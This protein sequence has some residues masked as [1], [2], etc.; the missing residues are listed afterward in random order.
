MR[1]T[2]ILSFAFALLFAGAVSAQ[3]F[4][5]CLN[6]FADGTPPVIHQTEAMQ[7]RALCFDGFAVLHSGRSKTPIFVAER[8]DSIALVGAK[9]R[10][11]TDKFF[12]DARLPRSE[13]AELDDYRGSGFDRGHLAPVG[14]MASEAAVAQSFSL[15]NMIPQHSINNR[16]I[17]VNIEK[18]TRKYVLRAAGDIYVITGPVFDG[19]TETIG[20]NHVWVPQ[21]LFKLIY[22]PGTG[23]RWAYW[24]DNTDDAKIG[25]PITYEE[26]VRR[27]GIEFMPAKS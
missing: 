22:D 21:H 23:R 4:E 8:L 9:D 2:R 27:T 20:D 13:R 3:D 25:Q 18:A 26:L 1:L 10:Q 6:L 24:L 11:R 12:A 15:A 16:K 5:D 17:W 7:M 19:T 14:D